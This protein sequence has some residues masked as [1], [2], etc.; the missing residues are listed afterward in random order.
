MALPMHSKLE[1]LHKLSW[2]HGYL[3]YLIGWDFKVRFPFQ[4]QTSILLPAGVSEPWSLPTGPRNSF[5]GTAKP[6]QHLLISTVATAPSG[7]SFNR[8]GTA[9][10]R[11]GPRPKRAC[12][13]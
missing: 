7:F 2:V 6:T 4:T 13:R 9:G 8:I 12:W 5:T 11:A 1:A 3:T 10:P